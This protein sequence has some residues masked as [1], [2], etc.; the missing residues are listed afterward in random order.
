MARFCLSLRCFEQHSC[1]CHEYD[2]M[3]IMSDLHHNEVSFCYPFYN[4]EDRVTNEIGDARQSARAP[5]RIQKNVI[6]SP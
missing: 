4:F 1:V 6:F 5:E 3:L 2:V